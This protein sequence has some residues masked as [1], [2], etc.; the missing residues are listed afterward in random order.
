MVKA[1]DSWLEC[2]EFETCAAEDPPCRGGRCKLNLLR[3]KLHP[4]GVVWKLGEGV[5]TQVSSSFLD[6]GSEFR[7][8][9]RIAIVLF[10]IAPLI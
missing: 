1:T 10:Y 4:V 8:S 5:P 3:L 6:H 2:H 7:G 9:L